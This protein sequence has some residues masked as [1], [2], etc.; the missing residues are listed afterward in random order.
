MGPPSPSHPQ[1]HPPPARCHPIVPYATLLSPASLLSPS[2]SPFV[3]T[4]HSPSI[5]PP[6]AALTPQGMRRGTDAPRL[7]GPRC[8]QGPGD[9]GA[10][11]RGEL[12]HQKGAG[13]GEAAL[14]FGHRK[15]PACPE[16]HPTA[17]GPAGRWPHTAPNGPTCPRRPPCAPRCPYVV[18]RGAG[19][20]SIT[21]KGQWDSGCPTPQ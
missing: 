16:H 8:P 4:T 10:G 18:V 13:S 12:H 21:W 1:C 11:S 20:A 15:P 17:A 19:A 9:A 7:M 3:P 14:H 2:P 6:R 5:S